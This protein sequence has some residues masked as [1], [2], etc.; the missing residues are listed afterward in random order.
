[1]PAIHTVKVDGV[2]YNVK[3]TH[4]ATCPTAAATTAK[5]AT[6][7][8]GEFALETGVKVNVK[9][10]YDNT[11]SSPTLNV[12]NTGAKAIYY[13]GSTLLTKSGWKAGQVVDFVYDGSYWHIVGLSDTLLWN[14]F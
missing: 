12:N 8:N 11:A 2:N 3:A 14:S 7:Q 6:I 4:Y 1:M 9:F 13:Q 10:S 5:I